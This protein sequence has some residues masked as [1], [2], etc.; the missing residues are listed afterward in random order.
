[1]G[2][3]GWNA[4]IR[5]SPEPREAWVVSLFYGNKTY[6]GGKLSGTNDRFF[7]ASELLVVWDVLT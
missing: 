5:S 7:I 3:V 2:V 6:G 1:M 4:W